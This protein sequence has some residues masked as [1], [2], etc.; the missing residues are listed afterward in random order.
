MARRNKRYALDQCALYRC[1]SPKKLFTR[2][3]MTRTKLESFKA[4]DDL[5]RPVT[6]KKDDGSERHT[7]DPRRDLK[8]IQGLIG[9]FLMRVE[10]PDYLMSPVRGRSNIDNAAAHQRSLAHRLLDIADF[11]PSCTAKKA[12]WFFNAVL[13]CPRDVA[14]IL[15]F[16]TTKDEA[17]PQGSPASPI[18]AYFAYS[19]MWSEIDQIAKSADNKLTVYVDDVTLSGNVV[20]G[21]TV[22]A[23]KQVLRRH[24]HRTKDN[25]EASRKGTAALVTGVVVRRGTLLLPNVQQANRHK[26]RLEAETAPDDEARLKAEASVAGYDVLERRIIETANRQR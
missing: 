16:L 21:E 14:G 4:A 10:P 22:H 15:T 26:R 17:L 24:G 23:I 9:E 5:Y 1:S 8:R 6:V 25:K 13:D 7:F 19:E 12:F 2:L 3:Q 11:Y 20:K 18:L